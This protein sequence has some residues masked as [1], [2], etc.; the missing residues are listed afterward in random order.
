MYVKSKKENKFKEKQNRLMQLQL[1]VEKMKRVGCRGGGGQQMSKRY[2]Q[3]TKYKML[4][5]E[6]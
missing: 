3:N 2:V 4:V 1:V 5:R 6:N